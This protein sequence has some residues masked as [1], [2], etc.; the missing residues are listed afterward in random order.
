MKTIL[1]LLILVGLNA[2]AKEVKPIYKVGDCAARSEFGNTTPIWKI[3]LVGKRQ[4]GYRDVQKPE[5]DPIIWSEN[6]EYFETVVAPFK[7]D[8]P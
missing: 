7:R 4:Y 1:I 2:S 3:S 5:R 6:F 8:C